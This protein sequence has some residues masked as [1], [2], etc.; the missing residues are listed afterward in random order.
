M[1]RRPVAFNNGNKTAN[2]IKK[3]KVEVGVRSD[4]YATNP[5]GLTWFN[6]LDSTNQYVIYSDTFSLGLT[7]Q[8]NSRPVCW[9]TGDLTDANLLSTVNRLPTR[10]NQAPFTTAS[11]ALAWIAQSTV[12]SIVGGALDNIVTNGLILNMDVSQRNSYPGSGTA[13]YDLAGSAT[14]TLVNGPTFNSSDRGALVFDGVND[15]VNSGYDLSWNNTNSVTID[16]WVRP[17]TV[18]G[19]NYGIMGKE[20]PDWE[21]AFY[22]NNKTINIVYWNTAGGHTNDMDF[23]VSAFSAANVWHHITYTWDGSTSIFYVNGVSVGSKTAGNPSLNQNRANNVMFGGHTYVWGDAYW[24]GRIGAVKFYNR[25][26]SA[27]EVTENY[28][29]SKGKYG[30]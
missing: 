28:N 30:L 1:S 13:M 2:S 7:T 12:F 8:A 25:A 24:S 20:H 3:N 5:G 22:Q 21:W 17:S 6:G 9:G 4:N 18:T 26:L 23:G 19:G 14:A 16:F 27:S 15:Y 11:A 10:S 29:A